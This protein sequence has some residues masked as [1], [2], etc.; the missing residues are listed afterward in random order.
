M[1]KSKIILTVKKM[2]F[3]DDLVF[4]E[5]YPTWSKFSEIY[6][7][8]SSIKYRMVLEFTKVNGRTFDWVSMILKDAYTNLLVEDLGNGGIFK[9]DIIEKFEEFSKNYK[10]PFKELEDFQSQQFSLFY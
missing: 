4:I 5:T 1:G 7:R 10:L 3:Q 6:Y 8:N 2:N 9:P